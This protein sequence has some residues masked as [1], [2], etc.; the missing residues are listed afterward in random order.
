MSDSDKV[1]SPFSDHY[2]EAV[3]VITQ[4]YDIATDVRRDNHDALIALKKIR[5]LFRK[6]AENKL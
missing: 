3:N 4:A 2:K 1:P 5:R 6:W